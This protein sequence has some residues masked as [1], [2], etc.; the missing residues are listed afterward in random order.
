MLFRMPTVLGDSNPRLAEPR[1]LL[2]PKGRREHGRFMLEGPTLLAEA[3]ASG[4]AI[5]E[6]Y[7]TRGALDRYPD[8]HKFDDGRLFEVSDRAITRIS[9]VETPAGIVAIAPVRYHPLRDLM[10]GDDPVVLL[11]GVSDPGNAGTLL[12]SADFFGVRKVIVGTA[13]ADP[14]SPKVVRSAMGSL[15]RVLLARAT[16]D[17]VESAARSSERPLIATA[18]SGEP[19]ASFH[20]PSRSIVAI[21]SERH[22]TAQ[23]P[24]RWNAVVTIP[25]RGRPESLNAAVAGSIVLYELTRENA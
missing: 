22:G 6:V 20:F 23:W 3:L 24:A 1:S 25:R 11:A 18:V 8:V 19:L 21:G 9:D 14:Y 13:T 12:R 16:P 2:T 4:I 5:S 17:D 15:F 7:A 10:D